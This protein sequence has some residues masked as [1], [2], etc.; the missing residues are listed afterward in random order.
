MTLSTELG[1]RPSPDDRCGVCNTL[2]DEHGDKRHEFNL[3]G[4]L[5]ELGPAPTARQQPP[6]AK[7]EPS[8]KANELSRDP[9][10]SLCLRL[11]ERLVAKGLFDG[12]DLMYIFGNKP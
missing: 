12:D 5:I 2:R 4:Q 6:Q 9:V 8:A 7:G 3:D 1:K 10:A 11:T